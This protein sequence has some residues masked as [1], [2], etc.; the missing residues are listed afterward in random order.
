MELKF[1]NGYGAVLCD[2]CRIIDMSGPFMK[3]EWDALI[4][5]SNN[6]EV[7]FCKE[8]DAEKHKEQSMKFVEIIGRMAESGLRHSTRNREGG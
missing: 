1:N 2:K 6:G 4:E 3:Y 5:M 7:W 8:C